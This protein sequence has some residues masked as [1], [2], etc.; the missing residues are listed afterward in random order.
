MTIAIIGAGM[1]GLACAE[2]LVAAGRAC[3]LFDKGRRPGGRVSTRRVATAAG[4]AT[5]DHGAQYVTVRDPAF[6]AR[7]EAWRGAGLVAPWPAAGPDAVVGVPA[8]DAPVAAMA[9]ALDVRPERRVDALW[10]EAGGWR[11]DGDGIGDG[12]YEAVVVTVPAE[13]VGALVAPW[14]EGLA[15]RAAA[16]RSEPC[17][18]IMAAFAESV[19]V[20]DDVVRHRGI[21]GWATRNSAK[22]GRTGPEAWVIQAGPDWSRANLGMDRAGAANAVLDAFARELGVALPEPTYASAHRWLYARAGDVGPNAIRYGPTWNAAL[23]LGACGDWSIGPRV[24]GAWLSG[25]RLAGMI[26]AA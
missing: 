22:P 4:E 2:A 1:A 26:L 15:A 5:F 19:A 25:H 23:A 13:Q 3:V 20:A 24:E 21:V 6:R 7:V 18:T 8:M 10:R 9:G 12:R 16:V 11:L 17:W 14:D